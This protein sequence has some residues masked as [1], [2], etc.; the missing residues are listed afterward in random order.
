MVRDKA[1][2]IGAAKRAHVQMTILVESSHH[3]SAVSKF[4][5]DFVTL[6]LKAAA[7]LIISMG[8]KGI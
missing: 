7:E 8:K 4:Q 2:D 3:L 1:S 6:N 5:A